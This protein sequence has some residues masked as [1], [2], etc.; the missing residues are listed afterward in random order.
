MKP[1]I[2]LAISFT[3]LFLLQKQRK[4]A[5]AYSLDQSIKNQIKV[6]TL[7]S[8]TSLDGIAGL[9]AKLAGCN[10]E[11]SHYAKMITTLRRK[12]DSLVKRAQLTAEQ[13]KRIEDSVKSGYK[14]TE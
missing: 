7:I 11:C 10:A 9:D 14:E 4:E 2:I 13:W 1:D 12:L 6:F 3:L 8:G 5:T